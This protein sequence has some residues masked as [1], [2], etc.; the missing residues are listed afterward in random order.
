MS[1]SSVNYNLQNLY[2]QPGQQNL[3]GTGSNQYGGGWPTMA[4]PGAGSYNVPPSGPYAA[5]TP[6][7]QGTQGGYYT[8]TTYDP[9]LTGSLFGYLGGQVGQGLPTYP[10]Q[11]TAAPNQLYGQL[12]NLLTGGQ[13]NLPY[14][15]Q[16]LQMA[17]TGNPTDVGPAWEAMKAAEQQN[18]QQNLA[19]LKEQFAA[20]GNL[21][22]TP[23]GS[24]VSDYESQTTL[25]QNAILTQAQQQA[26]EAAAGRQLSAQQMLTGADLSLGGQLQNISQMGATN[27][28]NEWLRTQPQYNPLLG[29]AYGAATTFPSY[30]NPQQSPWAMIIPA[31]LNAYQF[32]SG[33]SK[34]GPPGP[35][36]PPG[37]QAP[38]PGGQQTPPTFPGG[39]QTPQGG[40]VPTQQGPNAGSSS[41]PLIDPNTGQ[42]I[43]P[44]GFQPTDIS[45]NP[46]PTI[47]PQYDPSTG[48]WSNPL[49]GYPSS[50][51]GFGGGGTGGPQTLTPPA[52]TISGVDPYGVSNQSNPYFNNFAYGGDT[53]ANYY[54]FANAMGSGAM[55]DYFYTY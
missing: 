2:G 46:P 34:T 10:G 1:T 55:S 6:S 39:Q 25:G 9:S 53:S 17:Q 29:Q 3:F 14:G 44:P 33:G 19:Q 20:G 24:S 30:L 21:V 40:Q 4:T 51:G 12:G 27:A 50:L 15:Q 22:G 8:G 45:F 28:Y 37:Q 42:P 36:G 35:P 26:A 32:P 7:I 23:Y 18:I 38:G 54:D 47:N 16:M 48:T 5:Q 13:S 11:L 43:L 41:G 31:L 52:G 49:S